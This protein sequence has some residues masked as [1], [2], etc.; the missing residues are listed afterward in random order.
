LV[1]DHALQD[2]DPRLQRKDVVWQL[3]RTAGIAS[4]GGDLHFHHAPSFISAAAGAMAVL[5]ARNLPGM[6]RPSGMERLTASRTRIQPPFEPGTAPLTNSRPRSTSV[7]TILRL[8]VVTRISPR[9]PA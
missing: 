4:Q 6:G 5:G 8:S 2:V 7:L 9:C 1:A 3:D